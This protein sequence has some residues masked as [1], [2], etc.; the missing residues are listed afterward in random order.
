MTVDL[1][2]ISIH[3]FDVAITDLL[4]FVEATL[5]AYFLY[6]KRSTQILLRRLLVLLFLALG[7]SSLLGALFHAFFPAKTATGS[8]FAIWIA[9]ALFI[10]LIAIVVWLIDLYILGDKKL[11]KVT[12]PIPVAYLLIFVYVLFFLSYQFKIIILFYLP[13]MIFLA[14]ISLMKLIQ[15]KKRPW[16][17]LLAG[18]VLS[19]LAAAAQYLQINLHSIYFNYNALYHLVQGVALT[20]LF[21][22]F[23]KMLTDS[24]QAT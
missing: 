11:L 21:L 22:S 5:F 12:L 3:E 9:T 19:F 24:I 10:G 14:M 2:G 7:I 6:Q 4:L 16:F 17:W 13:P 8:G 20:L 1:V 15:T 23:Q 18:L